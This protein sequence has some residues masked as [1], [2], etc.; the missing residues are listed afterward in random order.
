MLRRSVSLLRR[1]TTP[2]KETIDFGF[3]TVPKDSKQTLVNQVF[4]SVA[5][6]YDVMNDLMSLGVHRIWKNQFIEDLGLLYC[7]S[8]VKFL[9]VAGGTG[10]IA[11]RLIEKMKTETAGLGE[12]EE[13]AHVTVLDINAAM[14]E[15]G[16]K[17]AQEYRYTN[18][19]WVEGNAESLPFPDNS[20]D[21]YTIAFGIR[22]VPDRL[23][24]IKEAHRVLKSGG[25]FMCLEFS[26][27]TNPVLSAIYDLH[28]FHI[29]PE[30]GRIVANDRESYQYLVE[31]IKKFPNQEEFAEIVHAAGFDSVTHKNLTMG[32]A[33]IHSGVKL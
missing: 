3:K 21:V 26:K 11:F 10:D 1:F 19:T 2:N 9:D 8:Q 27:V 22:N 7:G 17:R 30:I 28:S 14:L 33:A 5:G 15:V 32:I 12:R 6:N 25:R 13:T 23:Q 18:M 20:F 29:I 24:A 4:A 31:S 16:K